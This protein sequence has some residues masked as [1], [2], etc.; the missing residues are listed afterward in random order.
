MKGCT[1]LIVTVAL[2]A[3]VALAAPVFTG[4][5]TWRRGRSKCVGI[6]AGASI[7]LNAIVE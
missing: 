6:G 1:G 3:M 5:R 7:A 4:A 2:S